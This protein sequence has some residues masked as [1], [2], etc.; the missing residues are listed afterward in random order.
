MSYTHFEHEAF[1]EFG[2]V[3]SDDDNTFGTTL[4]LRVYY[5]SPDFGDAKVEDIFLMD[6]KTGKYKPLPYIGGRRFNERLKEYLHEKAQTHLLQ[7][8]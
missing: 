6:T 1:L 2:G 3:Y 4:K 8:R 5:S 7:S